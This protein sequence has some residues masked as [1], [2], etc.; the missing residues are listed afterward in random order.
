[1]PLLALP[2]HETAWAMTVHRSQGSE[3]ESVV[4]VLPPQEHELVGPELLYTGVTRAR[5]RILLAADETVLQAAC[6]QR[7]PRRTGLRDQL[8]VASPP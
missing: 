4:F 7:V 3:F 1:M 6:R 5:S 2:E 8:G